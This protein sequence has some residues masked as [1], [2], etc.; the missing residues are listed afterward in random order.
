MELIGA[1]IDRLTILGS[2]E[3]N[4]KEPDKPYILQALTFNPM[5]KKIGKADYPYRTSLYMVD[6]SIMQIADE[7]AE[8]A[9]VRYEFNPN[10]WDSPYTPDSAIMSILKLIIN[11]RLSRIDIALDIAGFNFNNCTV[12]D[13]RSRQEHIIKG[14]DKAVETAYY[15][16]RRSEEMVRIYNKWREQ[17]RKMDGND[18]S[19]WRVEAQLTGDAAEDWEER[20]PFKDLTITTAGEDKDLDMPTQAM[21]FYLRS[22]PEKINE[23]AKNTKRKY[24]KL[25]MASSTQTEISLSDLYQTKKNDLVAEVRMWKSL[26]QQLTSSKFD[27]NIPIDMDKSDLTILDITGIDFTW[28]EQ[29]GSYWI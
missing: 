6:G 5:V 18:S 2:Y 3:K 11:P 28:Q 26:T 16:T 29:S 13:A 10:N 23:L 12:T 8:V 17:G 9:P 1:S 24:Q 27:H 19:W 25:L 15:G 14:R 21:L 22:Y 20:D 7:S 4:V